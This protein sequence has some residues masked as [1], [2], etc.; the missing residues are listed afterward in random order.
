MEFHD[1]YLYVSSTPLT[2][3]RFVQIQHGLGSGDQPARP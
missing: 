1:N 2:R 3:R